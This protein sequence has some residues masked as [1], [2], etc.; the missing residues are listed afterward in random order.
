MFRHFATTAV[1][2][3]GLLAVTSC[4]SDAATSSADYCEMI[5]TYQAD[6][7]TYGDVFDAATPDPAA[8]EAAFRAISA[9]IDALSAKAPA[10]IKTDVAAM[11]DA[12]H[13]LIDL[14]EKYDW[15]SVALAQSDDLEALSTLM[16]SDAINSANERLEQYSEETCGID[17]GS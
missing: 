9:H 8:V 15:D 16:D 4:S 13:Q 3:L 17:A 11:S 6:S 2:T 7:D 5:R 1:L 14:F 12:T 10:S